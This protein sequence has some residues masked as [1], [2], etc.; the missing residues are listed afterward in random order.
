MSQNLDIPFEPKP[1]KIQQILS[2]VESPI[3]MEDEKH[4]ECMRLNHMKLLFF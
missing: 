2:D 4:L 3:Q 1:N